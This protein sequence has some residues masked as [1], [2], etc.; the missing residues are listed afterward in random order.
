MIA[1]AP[2][3]KGRV[4]LIGDAVHAI[5][6]HLSQGA[7]QAIEDGVVLADVRTRHEHL[8]AAFDESTVRRY[9]RCK[10]VVETSE[11][12]GA[13]EMG[14]LPDFDNIAATQRVLEIMAQPI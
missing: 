3:H 8:D 14:K 7:A 10:L 2:R 1:S 5:T 13:W 11:A 12:I 9:E 4:V 6:S